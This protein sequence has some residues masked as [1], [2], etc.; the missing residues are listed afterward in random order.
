VVKLNA[1]PIVST[2]PEASRW[3]WP[4]DYL[5]EWCRKVD[6]ETEAEWLLKRLVPSDA[7]I[8]MSGVAKRSFKTWLA[9][10]MCLALARGE[11]ISKLE[12]TGAYSSLILE[13][14]GARKQTRNRWT[15]LLSGAIIP[16]E[17]ITFIHRYPV[18]LDD[19]TWVDRIKTLVTERDIR[20]VVVDTLAKASR[21][22]ENSARDVGNVMRAIDV[23]RQAKLG[24]SVMYLHHLKKPGDP[25]LEIDIDDEVRG[26]SALQGFYDTH[27][28]L[29]KASSRSNSI[30]L[31]A[32]QKDDEERRFVIR[33]DILK[34]ENKAN[35]TMD[36]LSLDNLDPAMLDNCT[37]VLLQGETYGIRDLCRAWGFDSDM[38]T[39]IRDQL[40]NDE[41][42]VKT[43]RSGKVKL[44][45]EEP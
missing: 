16:P 24:C 2:A 39:A 9:F 6:T 41:V 22:D 21:A 19:P 26:S 12:P 31:T 15:Y 3:P 18:L 32:R 5:E 40:I 20:F 29:R 28:A 35:L 25:E 14:E 33:W 34:D 44:T 17:R 13:L 8:I 42:L 7:A 10:Q 27:L 36:E 37:A 23:I 30:N 1:L 43:G 38:V 4:P 45:Q 11:P